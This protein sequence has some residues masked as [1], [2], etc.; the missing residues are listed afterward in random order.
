MLFDPARNPAPANE[1]PEFH[2]ELHR[3]TGK[4][5]ARY[6]ADLAVGVSDLGM[7]LTTSKFAGLGLPVEYMSR[8]Q[9]VSHGTYYI[10]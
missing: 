8:G 7:H 4:V 2:I 10:K 5:R 1:D 3:T 9:C 6:E